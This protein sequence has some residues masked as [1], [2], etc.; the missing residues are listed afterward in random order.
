MLTVTPVEG[1]S[2]TEAFIRLP[3]RLAEGDPNWVEPLWL[4][5]RHFLSP[6]HNAFFSHGEARFWLAW[7]DGRPVGR[8]SAQTDRLAPDVE[9]RKQGFFGMLACEENEET[10]AALFGV[11]EGWLKAGGAGQVRGPFDLSVNQTSGLLVGGFDTPPFLMMGHDPA[12]LGPAVERRGYAKAKD[13]VAYRMHCAEGLSDR[14]RKLAERGSREVTIRSLDMRRYRE[15]IA[16]V[17]AIFNDA[18]AENWGFIPLT[19]AEV[20]AMAAE[21]KPIIDPGLVKIAEL[22]GEPVG[23]I[24]LLPNINDFIADLRGRLLPFGWLKLLWRVKRA[25]MRT[26]RVPLMGVK[27]EHARTL[28]GKTLPLRLIYAL[29]DRALER[30]IREL[31]LSWL[32]EDNQNVRHVVEGV[33]GRL[34]KTYRIYEKLLT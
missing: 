31:E 1:R 23:F 34:V 5:R 27:R 17:T 26:G 16:S 6:K 11:A 4:E 2:Q 13:L 22:R 24:I 9:G 25:P 19:D 30:G 10:L 18:W 15:E 3:G 12:W 14:M 8:I 7:R 33:G 21:M 29:E 20:D 32:L 28:V